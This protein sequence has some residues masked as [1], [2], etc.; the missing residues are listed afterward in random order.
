MSEGV[1]NF[2]KT[3]IAL[4]IEANKHG[5]RVHTRFPPEPNGYLHI[6]HAKSICLNFALADEYGG[7]CNL[8]FDD[9]N[10][11]KESQ[12]YVDAIKEN[13]R[14]LGFN[15][16]G[17]VRY[18]SS[19]FQHL[20][21]LAE[22]LIK[23]GKA[24]VCS[25]SA[26][27]SREYRGTL[28]APGRDSPDRNRSIADNLTLFNGM[29]DGKFVDGSYTLRA[30]IDMSSPNINMRDPILYRIR[31][32]A[33]HQ[34]GNDWC[35]Y[36]TYD[37][38]HC[39]SDAIENITHSFCTLEFEDHRPLYDWILNG[40]DK[41]LVLGISDLGE[42]EET[43]VLPEQTEFAKLKLNYTVIGKRSL[44]AMV[45]TGVVDGWDDPRLPTLAGMRRRGFTASS[46]RAFCQSI[47]VSRSDSQVDL[48][49]LEHCLREDLDQK[50][51]RVMC[52]LNPI[53]ITLTNIEVGQ[54]EELRLL[55][56]PKDES[57]GRRVV[58]FTREIYIDR[59]DFEE[60]PPEG[61]KRL[62]IGGEVRLR[63]SYIIKCEK[64]IKSTGGEVIELL[65]QVDKE[66][67][68]KRPQGRK[69]KGVIHWVSVNHGLPVTLRL[70]DR[71]FSVENPE[72]NGSDNY[73]DFINP[74]SL[75]TVENCIIEP[76]ALR[77]SSSKS[78]QFEREG[79]FVFDEGASR[80][81]NIVFNR[82][83]SL[84]DSWG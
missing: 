80:T 74:N 21:N 4:D 52:V 53:K 69:V 63:G 15:W 78:F 68:G 43:I 29:R 58:P 61:F 57:M 38:T 44:K 8:R 3:K 56:H 39:L 2:L 1:S 50:A 11:E 49:M 59:A 64:A 72:A 6:G 24:F 19:Y 13:I 7:V 65:C 12:E 26:E 17:E 5:G 51:V 37:Y 84:R 76:S 33:H 41:A 22:E 83:I 48:G 55:N 35:I 10:P 14:W 25:L 31:H 23:S 70:Y 32:V 73:M 20:F 79:Y 16:N 77:D 34:T 40:L 66:T 45:E 75:K 62:V 42:S 47:G 71:L 9:T 54:M 60:S 30:K 82:T 81:G 18:S 36:P 46:I 28:I 67:L 27:E